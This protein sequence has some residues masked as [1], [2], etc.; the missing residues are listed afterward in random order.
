MSTPVGVAGDLV[1]FQKVK[2]VHVMNRTDATETDR[3]AKR[4]WV[5]N[6]ADDESWLD[7]DK[8]VLATGGTPLIPPI[9]WGRIRQYLHASR[10]LR[11]RRHRGRRRLSSGPPSHPAGRTGEPFLHD[12][13]QPTAMS[14]ITTRSCFIV[15]PFT[16]GRFIDANYTTLNSD[17]AMT[18]FWMFSARFTK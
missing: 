16:I 17:R 14:M 13:K 18:S 7:C 8:L 1:F 9:G 10:R 2:N 12:G 15:C 11:R 4:V 5:R 3:T 6:V